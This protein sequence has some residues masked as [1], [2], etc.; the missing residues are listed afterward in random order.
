MVFKVQL[1]GLK[2]LQSNLSPE[3]FKRAVIRALDRTVKSGKSEAQRRIRDEY[4]IKLG[5]LSKRVE[6]DI[7][8]SRLEAVINVKGKALPLMKF[9]PKQVIEVRNQKS[10]GLYS[11]LRKTKPGSKGIASTTVMVKMGQRKI[12]QGGFIPKL[13]SGHK[14]IFKRIGKARYPIKQLFT[15][16]VHNMFGSQRVMDSVIKRIHEQWNKNIVHEITE[17][18]KYGNK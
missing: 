6:V 7:H 16:D 15:I 5:D 3:K 2:E 1:T 13:N 11:K 12:V 18:W 10:K 14:T 8:P 9:D 17:G 4:N